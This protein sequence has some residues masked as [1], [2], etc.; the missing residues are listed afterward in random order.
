MPFTAD[1][2][3]LAFAALFFVNLLYGINYVVAK[4]L[5]P[6]VIGPSGFIL[7][8]VVGANLLFWPVWLIKRERVAWSDAKRLV[9]CGISGVAVNQLMFFHG[10]MRTSAIHASIIMV[11]TPILVLVLSG[12]LIGERITRNKTIGVAL[13]ATGALLLIFLGGG[14]SDGSSTLGDLFILVNASSYAVFLVMVKPL[15]S[16]YSAVTVMSWCFLVGSLLVVPFGW[17]EFTAVDWPGLSA[18]QV[19]GLLFVVVMV[20]FVAYLLNT[21]ALRV[22]QPSVAGTFIYLQPVLA[23]VVTWL[24]VKGGVELGWMQGFSALCIFLG[25]WLVGRKERAAE[26]A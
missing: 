3:I 20:T 10:L 19:A 15:M 25:V 21:W 7:L 23:L 22:V 4:G 12:L 6:Q 14:R 11:A 5:M 13:G 8:R 1:R 18:A 26:A 9:L 2:R 24:T 16:K 17:G